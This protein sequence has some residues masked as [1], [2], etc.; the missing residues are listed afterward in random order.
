MMFKNTLVSPRTKQ[1]NKY[2]L[3][4]TKEHGTYNQASN[5][6]NSKKLTRNTTP[7]TNQDQN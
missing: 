1:Q 2:C 5:Y 7:T 3:I 4:L 6:A